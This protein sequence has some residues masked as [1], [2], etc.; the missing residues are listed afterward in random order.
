MPQKQVSMM[1]PIFG[2]KA[3][4]MPMY[5]KHLNSLAVLSNLGIII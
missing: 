4:K 3:Q 5:H 2:V 1:N